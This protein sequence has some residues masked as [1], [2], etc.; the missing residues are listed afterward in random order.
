MCAERS[1]TK[2]TKRWR[3]RL[4]TLVDTSPAAAAAD[5]GVAIEA[6]GDSSSTS[7]P[8]SESWS[9]ELQVLPH[10]SDSAVAE[11]ASC[12][13]SSVLPDTGDIGSTA[14]KTSTAEHVRTLTC[15]GHLRQWEAMHTWTIEDGG[16]A[17]GQLAGMGPGA[18]LCRRRG[19]DRGRCGSDVGVGELTNLGGHCA[20]QPQGHGGSCNSDRSIEL[21]ERQA[22]STGRSRNDR[23]QCIKHHSRSSRQ[24]QVDQVQA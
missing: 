21:L 19:G 23:L 3:R 24:S 20:V 7:K 14:D 12:S 15:T 2:G 8:L 22:S 13:S 5:A 11:S 18:Q 1:T 17:S 10:D 6:I 4:A 9:S 16:A